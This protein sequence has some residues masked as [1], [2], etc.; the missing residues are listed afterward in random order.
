MNLKEAS[1]SELLAEIH[2]LREQN[3]LLIKKKKLF[4]DGPVVVFKWQNKKN[5]PVEYVSP[6]VTK[7]FGYSAD[8]FVSENILY[9]D[10]ILDQDLERVISEVESVCDDN[11]SEFDHLPYRIKHKDG[12]QRWL[13]DHTIVVRDENNDILFFYGYIFDITNRKIIDK[14]L[15]EI[16]NRYEETQ[17]LAH[18]GSWTLDIINNTLEWS[19]EVYRI[20]N[21]DPKTITPTYQF[22]LEMVYPDDREEVNTS[23]LNSVATQHAYDITHRLLLK[24]GTIKYVRERGKTIYDK[25]IVAIRSIGTIQDISQYK[26]TERLLKES[27]KNLQLTIDESEHTLIDM[28]YRIQA[29]I[30]NQIKIEQSLREHQK[31]LENYQRILSCIAEFSNLF[32]HSALWKSVIE[33]TLSMLGDATYVSRVYLFENFKGDNEQP[34][35]KQLYE[36]CADDVKSQIDNIN[37]QKFDWYKQSLD[38]WYEQLSSNNVISRQYS[39][40]TELEHN[41]LDYQNILSIL[42]VPVFVNNAF[43]G[44]IGFDECI[45]ERKWTKMEI[46]ALKSAAGVIGGAIEREYSKQALLESEQRFRGLV[47]STNDWIWEVN[48]NGVYTYS[49]PSV[50]KILG[51]K[52]D[53]VIG[54]TPFDF[55]PPEES[56]IIKSQFDLFVKSGRSFLNLENLNYHKNGSLI[57]IETSC[58]PIIDSDGKITGFRGIDRDISERKLAEKNRL[59]QSEQQKNELVREVHHR[60]KNHLQGLMGLLKQRSCENLGFKEII[61]ETITQIESIATIYGLQAIRDNSQILFGQMVEAI[62]KS[63]SSLSDLEIV[64][65]YGTESGLREVDRDK[66]VALALV[67]NELIINAIKHYDYT[68]DEQNIFIHHEHHENNITLSITNPGLLPENF[69]FETGQGFGTGLELLKAMLPGKGADLSINVKNNN[70]VA[71]LKIYAP[72]LVDILREIRK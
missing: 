72:L 63:A 3:T 71:T 46:A 18:L 64:V 9:S 50:E 60:I 66:A 7:I 10:V 62:I 52:A 32:L 41:E 40:Y 15:E 37:L 20:F 57:A 39:N 19:P 27:C 68:S 65:T 48:I 51:Y 21:V 1:K 38:N 43:W 59:K 29:G 12:T 53:E 47:E 6:N 4:F 28:G 31:A 17:H 55:M 36:W 14:K 69:N 25:N 16:Q 42:L 2:Q 22:F 49:S 34:C 11:I 26:Q 23:Y 35:S 45:C 56:L 54:K 67:V 33:H 70:V 44:V 30:K 58:V 61:N 8:D 5:W 24:D 13:Y